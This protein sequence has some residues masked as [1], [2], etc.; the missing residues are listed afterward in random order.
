MAYAEKRVARGKTYFRACYQRPDRKAQGYVVDQDGRAVRYPTK[1]TAQK[2]A[3]KAEAE[4]FEEA[5][6]GRWVPP[7]Q[8]AASRKITFGEM[9]TQATTNL[10]LAAST[11]QNYAKSLAHLLPAFGDMAICDITEGMVATWEESNCGTSR[12]AV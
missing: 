12:S 5:K 3:E 11:E 9:A 7:E 2:A 8:A 10:G 6:K 1:T 4:A